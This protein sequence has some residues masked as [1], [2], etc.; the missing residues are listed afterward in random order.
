MSRTG[1][2]YAVAC[3]IPNPSFANQTKTKITNPELRGISQ[4]AAGNALEEFTRRKVNEFQTITDFLAKERKAEAAA[5]RARR[6]VLDNVLI[7]NCVALLQLM[8]AH[9]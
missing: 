4:R 2:V 8:D 7:T 6:Q 9:F 5:E 1:L 3:K